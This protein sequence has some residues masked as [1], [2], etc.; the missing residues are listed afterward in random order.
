LP[1]QTVKSEKNMETD[2]NNNTQSPSHTDY[3]TIDVAVL[4]QA[5]REA[6]D[7]S[8]EVQALFIKTDYLPALHSRV[9]EVDSAMK[10]A[11]FKLRE[12]TQSL[13]M[14]LTAFIETLRGYQSE[15]EEATGSE[16]Q[17]VL[18]DI[19]S[20]VSDILGTVRQDKAGLD[21]IYTPMTAAVDRAATGKYLIQM[22]ADMQ[23]L[24]PE[25]L[26][27][28]ERQ[29]ALNV[30]RQ[31]LTQA[32][33]LIESKGF[34]EVGKE[35]LLNAQNIAALAAAGPQAA[36][37]TAAIDL[38]QQILERVES[39]I[40]YMGLMDARNAIRRQMDVVAKSIQHKNAELRLVEMKAELIK[41]S[42][43]FEEQRVRYTAEFSKVSAAARSFINAYRTVDA[44]DQATV[45][46]F[47]VE[48]QDLAR[49][50]KAVI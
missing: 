18:E 47:A 30:K 27:V 42:H 15:L 32:M 19:A 4:R 8:I 34:A 29:Q 20:V 17:E 6:G 41:Q 37:L 2:M 5:G 44:E 22:T 43:A 28:K 21:G 48:A 39:S 12:T 13:A 24:P 14:N 46:Q 38:G 50:M 11:Q 35:T 40:N 25:I 3:P 23:R 7:A 31:T 26:E 45:E 33:A 10:T 16:K 49:Y 36:V 1:Q 9:T